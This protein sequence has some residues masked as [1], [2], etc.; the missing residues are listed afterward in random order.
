MNIII[1]EKILSIPPYI[2]TSWEN[3]LSLRIEQVSFSTI[4]IVE[5]TSGTQVEIPDLPKS[6]IESAFAAH[7]ASIS[8]VNNTELPAEIPSQSMIFSLPLSL[9][10]ESDAPSILEHNPDQ[11]NLPPLP[12]V[13]LD[14]LVDAIKNLGFEN[15]LNLS[16]AE[17]HC[18]CPHCQ[19]MRILH[20]EITS[21]KILEEEVIAEEEL[22]FKTWSIRD[23]G[24]KLF[25]VISPLDSLETY[26]VSLGD[27]LSCSCGAYHCEHLQAVLKS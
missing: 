25:T 15:A 24:N 17:P 26:R 21:E 5:L 19:I 4:L 18:N 2:S 10:T 11:A 13:I 7:A 27:P 14:K 16:K 3:V 1:S 12:P 6:L 8:H 20:K 22:T 9:K 23:E